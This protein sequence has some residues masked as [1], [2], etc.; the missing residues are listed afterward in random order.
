METL[1]LKSPLHTLSGDELSELKLDFSALKTRDYS[2]IVRLE[3]RLKGTGETLDISSLNKKASVEFRIATAWIAAL[4]GTPKIC[5]DD[6][7]N[8]SLTDLMELDSLAV[9]FIVLSE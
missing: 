6:I 5:L 9:N 8:L 1:K 7:D 3:S 2:K 4:K